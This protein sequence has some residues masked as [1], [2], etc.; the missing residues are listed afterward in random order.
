MVSSQVLQKI[1]LSCIIA[2]LLLLCATFGLINDICLIYPTIIE[3]HNDDKEISQDKDPQ[4]IL[5]YIR[6]RRYDIKTDRNSYFKAPYSPINVII[7]GKIILYPATIS[8]LSLFCADLYFIFSSR[9]FRSDHVDEWLRYIIRFINPTLLQNLVQLDYTPSTP[10]KLWMGLKSAQKWADI[11]LVVILLIDIVFS[12]ILAKELRLNDFSSKYVLWQTNL[13]LFTF[14]VVALYYGYNPV[15]NGFLRSQ[16]ISR[17]PTRRRLLAVGTLVFSG[18]IIRPFGINA[19]YFAANGRLANPRY[20][21]KKRP[22]RI[23]VNLPNGLYRNPK[24]RKI[25]YVDPNGKISCY[26]PIDAGRLI[27]V[28]NF[29]EANFPDLNPLAG[30]T[31]FEKQGLSALRK[32]QLADAIAWL[33]LGINYEIFRRFQVP[34]HKINMRVVKLFAGLCYRHRIRGKIPVIRRKLLAANMVDLFQP[35]PEQWLGKAS[36]FKHRWLSREK[37][38]GTKLL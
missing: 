9:L 1:K 4:N 19:A 21:R 8:L 11:A 24:S 30:K 16:I 14:A 34:H 32:G 20:R 27:R 13:Q 2:F 15:K 22:Q 10:P 36:N 37:Y 26:G 6:S 33:E 17:S 7:I 23:S 5:S 3:I 28:S 12:L 18:L 29:T 38:D 25:L 35:S 31:C